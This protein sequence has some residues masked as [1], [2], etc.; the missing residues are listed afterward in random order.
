MTNC[1]C[2]RRRTKLKKPCA[3]N[4]TNFQLT[5]FQHRL[6][7][8][9]NNGNLCSYGTVRYVSM[10]YFT[11]P[12]LFQ[13][14]S[15]HISGNVQKMWMR[16]QQQGSPVCFIKIYSQCY[17]SAEW[18]KYRD[19]NP[20]K[21][22]VFKVDFFFYTNLLKVLKVPNKIIRN[23]MCVLWIQA[24]PFCEQAKAEQ[25]QDVHKVLKTYC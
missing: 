16:T 3:L 7:T 25:P 4:C 21:S 11:L 13:W 24:V 19:H 9:A 18:F 20:G 15:W 8:V 23:T 5:Q 22:S 6:F 2:L 12:E 14:K 17:L 1:W 10:A